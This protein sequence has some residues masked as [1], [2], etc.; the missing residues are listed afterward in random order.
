M[1]WIF[2]HLHYCTQV[3]DKPQLWVLGHPVMYK[4]SLVLRV[5][6]TIAHSQFPSWGIV[7]LLVLLGAVHKRRRNFLAV[8]ENPFPHVGYSEI[9]PWFTQFLPL[10]HKNFRPQWYMRVQRVIIKVF[11]QPLF[12]AILSWICYLWSVDKIFWWLW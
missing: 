10:Q 12:H 7:P 9:W 11:K 3:I 4:R 8:F 6:S 2:F 1:F 5:G